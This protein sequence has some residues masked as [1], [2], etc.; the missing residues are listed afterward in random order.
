MTSQPIGSQ[1]TDQISKLY[2]EH[3]VWLHRWLSQRLGNQDDAADLAQETF[4]R[5]LRKQ[6]PYHYQQPRALLTTIAK[7]L[8]NTWW[9]RKQIEQ[10]YYETL[11][12][13][14]D[15]YAPSPEQE[16]IAIQVLQELQDVLNALKPRAKQIFM[17]SQIEGLS[18]AQIAE[19]LDIALITVK[20]DMHQ[21]MLQCLLTMQL[22]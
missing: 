3:H 20:R 13:R 16:L 17:L 2:Q 8:A 18:Y 19:Q 10:A 9:Q 11:A 1:H 7:N 14:E 4:F 5:L 15:D 6:Y 12:Q 21:A 22:D